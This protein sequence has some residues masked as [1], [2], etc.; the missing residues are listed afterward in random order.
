ML[1]STLQHPQQFQPRLVQGLSPLGCPLPC[2]LP[3][4]GLSGFQEKRWSIADGSGKVISWLLGARV[5][6]TKGGSSRN[7]S[8]AASNSPDVSD[9]VSDLQQPHLKRPLPPYSCVRMNC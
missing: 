4:S 1:R 3:R 5:L 6:I 9:L 2:R 8:K 7:L